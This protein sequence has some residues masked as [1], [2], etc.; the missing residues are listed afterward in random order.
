M[1]LC[2]LISTILNDVKPTYKEIVG[3]VFSRINFHFT[4]FKM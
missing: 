3:K 4:D 2:V 1:T